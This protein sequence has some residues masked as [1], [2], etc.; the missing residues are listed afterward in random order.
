[1]KG[2]NILLVLL[3]AFLAGVIISSLYFHLGAYKRL[4]NETQQ[5]KEEVE[6]RRALQSKMEQYI[7]RL[8][9]SLE[10]TNDELAKKTRLVEDLQ[11]GEKPVMTQ[12]GALLTIGRS[13][14]A[15]GVENMEPMGVR[16][17]VSVRQQRVYCWMH[18]ING[19][20]EKITVRW[21]SKGGKIAEAH[22]PIG[23][24][25]WRT[26]AYITLRPD[27]IG[28]AVAEIL[29]ENGVLLKALS[30]QIIEMGNS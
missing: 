8:R 18:V 20:G 1:M 14:I 5:L 21:I 25:S 10:E 16:Q 22:L 12:T 29:D 30:F 9:T 7:S 26:W 2:K 3:A 15:L 17:R 28:P 24:N 6:T 19:Q 27:M 13:A 11:A 4:S 23:S